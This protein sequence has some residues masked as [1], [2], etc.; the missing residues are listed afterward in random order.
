[1]VKS[2]GSDF[3]E[4]RAQKKEREKWRY[5]HATR[6]QRGL[7]AQSWSGAIHPLDIRIGSRMR[8]VSL[9]SC[10]LISQEICPE[11]ATLWCP[12][13]LVLAHSTGH[14]S[15]PAPAHGRRAR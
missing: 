15:P 12:H 9:T 6:R 7:R 10:N 1:M 13:S 3:A 4:K 14:H 8:L 11:W 2:R 5:L